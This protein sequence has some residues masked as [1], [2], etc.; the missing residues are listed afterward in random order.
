MIRMKRYHQRAHG[1]TRKDDALPKRFT[2]PL[3]EGPYKGEAFPRKVLEKMLDYYYEFRG[4]SKETGIPAREKLEELELGYVANELGNLG[5]LP[6]RRK[7][8]K[9]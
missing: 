7:Q 5:V 2:E 6:T 3:P 8:A 9:K 4:W 1:I